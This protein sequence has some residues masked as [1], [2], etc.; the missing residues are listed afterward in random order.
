MKRRGNE[1]AKTAALAAI[2][3]MV[4]C[5]YLLA[6]VN[7][8]P[9]HPDLDVYVRGARDLLAGRP[10]YDAYLQSSADPT[11]RNGF[12][13]PPVFAILLAPLAWVPANAA[14][15]LW[16]IGTQAALG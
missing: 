9:P 14:P 4:G 6:I 10:L 12:I 16:L 8:V 2:V 7:A 1:T 3:A 15:T 5:L 11:L 13:Y